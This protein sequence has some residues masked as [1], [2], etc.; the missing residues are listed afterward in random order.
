MTAYVRSMQELSKSSDQLR[1][2]GMPKH[3]EDIEDD[4]PKAKVKG[5]GK[6]KSKES[7]DSEKTES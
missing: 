6:G 4:K 2:K 1:K 3:D 5:K 7:K